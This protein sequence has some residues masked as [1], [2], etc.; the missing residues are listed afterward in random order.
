MA[1][2]GVALAVHFAAWVYGL[3]RTTLAHALLLVSCHPILLVALSW[4]SAVAILATCGWFG[5]WPVSAS[6]GQQIRVSDWTPSLYLRRVAELR[7]CLM[8]NHSLNFEVAAGKSSGFT[9]LT[10]LNVRVVPALRSRSLAQPGGASLSHPSSDLNVSSEQAQSDVLVQER[11]EAISVIRGHPVGLKALVDAGA[12][13]ELITPIAGVH[14]L[15]RM[16]GWMQVE[17]A[18]KLGLVREEMHAVAVPGAAWK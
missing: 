9:N 16:S 10:K 8:Y 14:G 12:L 7:A 4:G 15:S 11:T 3:D 6:C 2:S 1:V 18:R 17:L 5:R 13:K